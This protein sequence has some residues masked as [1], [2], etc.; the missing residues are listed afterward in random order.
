MGVR[1]R[2]G[3]AA[4]CAVLLLAGAR[5]GA[6]TV[7]EP[8]ARLSL[9]GGYDSNVRYDGESSDRMTRVSPDAG[10][11]LRDHLWDA[12]LVYGADWITYERLAPDGIW[13][14]RGRFELE[15]TPTRRLEL[16]ASLRGAWAFDPIG[17]AQVGVFRAGRDSAL[18]INGRA[19]AEYRA[20]RRVDVAA[21]FRERTVLFE[22][23]TGGAMHAP[24][25]EALWR[26]SRR[27]S[28]G[29]AYGLG[30]FQDFAPDGNELAFS[31]AARARARWRASRRL[32]VEAYAGPAL[33]IATD[34]DMA[35]VPE[36]AV[37][38]LGSSRA[39]DL[40]TELSHGLGI[41]ATAQPGLVDSVE[42]GV[43]RRIGHRFVL[44]GD[45][46]LWRS[47]TIP[48]GGGA[49]TGYAVGGE[50]GV[51]VGMNL[52]LAAGARHLARLDDD[53][54]LRRTTMGLTLAWE[55]SAR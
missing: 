50:A 30:L 31:H 33:W 32:A 37:E 12:R 28:V 39:W 15:A 27:L 14:H 46:G 42:L 1:R 43:V 4:L 54:E 20:S 49:V 53:P 3:K 24:G 10:V 52:R 19:R 11:R 21:T 51:L 7:W 47:G 26:A 40:R 18:L 29:A 9:E 35:I 45:G 44:R 8:I 55:L 34:G 6:S 5:S 36:V 17:L 38:V 23:E 41:G 22:D 16:Q 2:F 25:A 13:N 48:S